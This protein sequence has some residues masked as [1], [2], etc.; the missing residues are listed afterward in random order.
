M[1]NHL[2]GRT[3]FQ[4]LGDQLGVVQFAAIVHGQLQAEVEPAGSVVAETKAETGLAGIELEAV[5]LADA[6]TLFG[7]AWQLFSR[8][9]LPS[10][11]ILAEAVGLRQ[12]VK[13]GFVD[14]VQ[15]QLQAVQGFQRR[16]LAG[17]IA[18]DNRQALVSL[19]GD[20]LWAIV[21]IIGGQAV[22]AVVELQLNAGQGVF[23]Q[24]LD[25][26]DARMWG[27]LGNFFTVQLQGSGQLL[28][29]KA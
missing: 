10:A 2:L 23:S 13:V 8:Q 6:P 28:V 9:L 5:I 18:L 26:G 27:A 14:T 11:E 12:P 20:A 7:Q 1:Q 21:L 19:A 25:T 16:L 4:P 15:P 3:L 24:G 22:G 17:Q 29:V